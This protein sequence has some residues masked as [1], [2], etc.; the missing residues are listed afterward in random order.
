MES[1]AARIS[2]RLE[3]LASPEAAQFAQRF[4]KTGAGEYGEGDLFRGIRVP[5]LR[6]LSVSLDDAPLPEIIQLLSSPWHEDRLLALLLLMRR[7]KRGREVDQEEIYNLY[8]AHTRHINNWDLVDISAP[9]IVGRFLEYRDRSVLY[10]LV[11]SC[12]LWERRIAILSTMHFI[13]QGE[14]TDT[15]LLAEML[16][17]DK[18]ELLHKATGWMLRELGKRDPAALEGF[19]SKHFRTMPRVMLR[20][21]IERFPEEKRQQYLKG[22][23]T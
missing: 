23:C 6:K 10:K 12:S 14:F 7:F 5:L 4:F 11:N 15:I 17:Q 22:H 9:H 1:T 3:A 2:K 13:R 19:L 16:L 21:A 18:E 20:Y 8:L